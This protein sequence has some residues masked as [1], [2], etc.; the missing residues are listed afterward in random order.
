MF[1]SPNVVILTH[2]SINKTV[3]AGLDPAIHDAASPM[4]QVE[5]WMRG[6]S[7]RM[8]TRKESNVG[9]STLLFSVA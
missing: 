2:G 1:C 3:I 5:K 8:T 4:E 9:T 6:S 7:P